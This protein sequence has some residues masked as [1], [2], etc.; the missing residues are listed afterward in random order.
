[1]FVQARPEPYIKK[2]QLLPKTNDAFSD[3]KYL[4]QLCLTS[5]EIKSSILTQE[6]A[7]KLE[8]MLGVSVKKPEKK[9]FINDNK[10]LVDDDVVMMT[11]YYCN[12]K[13]KALLLGELPEQPWR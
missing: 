7:Q 11:S 9:V 3:L 8:N 12:H 4:E 1:M 2:F 5:K 6:L 13:R 10:D